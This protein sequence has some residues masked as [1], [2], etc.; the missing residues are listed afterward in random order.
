MSTTLYPI[1]TKVSIGL[2]PNGHL[3]DLDGLTGEVVSYPD[4]FER[5]LDNAPA[6][7][8]YVQIQETGEIVGLI[9][10]QLTPI[11]EEVAA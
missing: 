10:S 8:H 1:G 9:S 2:D 5:I 11:A 4:E 6:D 3:G 7:G